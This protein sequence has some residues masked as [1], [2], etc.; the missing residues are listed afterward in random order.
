MP[1]R[2]KMDTIDCHVDSSVPSASVLVSL[3]SFEFW[4]FAQNE[5]LYSS[6]SLGLAKQT[7]SR[8][9]RSVRTRAV[10]IKSGLIQTA[11]FTGET[12][13]SKMKHLV[14]QAIKFKG[15]L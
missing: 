8:L 2:S 12:W 5:Y 3:I 7:L 15:G 9:T 11:S 1:S 13:I 6:G 14:Q 4:G 10:E